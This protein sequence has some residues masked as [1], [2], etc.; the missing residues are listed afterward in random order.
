MAT[1][2]EQNKEQP[3]KTNS[4]RT[5]FIA[6][7][8]KKINERRCL[9][10][11]QHPDIYK[12]LH[13]R[14][15]NTRFISTTLI[16][17]LIIA[18][19]LISNMIVS[20]KDNQESWISAIYDAYHNKESLKKGDL[21]IFRNNEDGKRHVGVF[22][23]NTSLNNL[24][25]SNSSVENP[26][27]T[28]GVITPNFTLPSLNEFITGKTDAETNKTESER[29][30]DSLATVLITFSL[31]IFIGFVMRAV[32]IFTR[33]Y[34]QL[35]TDYDNQKIAYLLCKLEG[36]EFGATLEEL[37]SNKIHF[38]KTPLPPQEKIVLGLIDILK[39]RL[40]NSKEKKE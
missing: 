23:G 28:S 40:P 15:R 22:I 27:E 24:T 32:L 34:M 7:L 14:S 39:D 29:V 31:V 4:K 6:I 13:R 25:L 30:A 38:E 18:A 35:A 8:I 1:N 36:K 37:R 21:V 3:T 9:K 2:Y 26:T 17:I 16:I 33:Y 11:N 19:T 12:M 5:P 10:K 20:W